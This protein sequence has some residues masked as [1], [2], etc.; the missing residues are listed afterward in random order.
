MISPITFPIK[1]SS[2]FW[3]LTTLIFLS[4]QSSGFAQSNPVVESLLQADRD[5][6]QMGKEKGLQTAFTFFADQQAILLRDGV[7]PIRGLEAIRESFAP[8]SSGIVLVWEPE[9]AIVAESGDLG[10]TLGHHQTLDPDGK[11]LSKGTYTTFWKKNQAGEWK[12]TLDTGIQY[13]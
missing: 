11:V 7:E 1:S 5:F 3:M 13:P 12:W 6:A 2:Y 9:F 10:Y 4:F 8:G